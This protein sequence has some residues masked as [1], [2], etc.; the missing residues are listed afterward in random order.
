MTD[1]PEADPPPR[2]F[3]TNL[4]L[5]LTERVTTLSVQVEAVRALL[6]KEGGVSAAELDQTMADLRAR[7]QLP[8]H[9]HVSLSQPLTAD[10]Y[11]L[12]IRR[13]LKLWEDDAPPRE[14]AS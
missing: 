5:L 8:E 3:L 9:P 1:D 4:L 7:W 11:A 6:E 2:D 12:R 14:S 10:E 13:L